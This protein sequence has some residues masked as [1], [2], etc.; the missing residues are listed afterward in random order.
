VKKLKAVELLI[1]AG[2]DIEFSKEWLEDPVFD[3]LRQQGILPC[4]I[5]KEVQK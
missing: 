5:I 1:T 4:K 3:S 2:A